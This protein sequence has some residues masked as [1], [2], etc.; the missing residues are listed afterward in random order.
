MTGPAQVRGATNT[1]TTSVTDASAIAS[2]VIRYRATGQ[3]RRLDDDLHGQHRA[4]LHLHW[5]VSALADASSWEL[6]AVATDALGRTTTSASF[7]SVVNSTGPTGTDVQSTNGG[8]NDRLDSGDRVIFTFS[9]AIAP[10]SILT[11][12]N[13]SSTAIRVR[14]DNSGGSDSMEL[15]RRHEHD[16]AQPAGERDRADDQR[17][18]RQRRRRGSTPRSRAP[19]RPSR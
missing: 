15:L 2:V 16:A 6:I 7:T 1:V 14:V 4:D 9:A 8:T 19:A 3:H 18:P 13:G 10:A 17:R 11:G 5:N 12:W